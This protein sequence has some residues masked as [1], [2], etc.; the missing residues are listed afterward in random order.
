MVST[1]HTVFSEIIEFPGVKS[2]SSHTLSCRKGLHPESTASP[3]TRPES[4]FRP[5]TRSQRTDRGFQTV[6]GGEHPS[7]EERGALH[8][9]WA[10]CVCDVRR[11]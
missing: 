2:H 3:T 1:A 8:V 7:V 5:S 6:S 11:A 10:W 9:G 4:D